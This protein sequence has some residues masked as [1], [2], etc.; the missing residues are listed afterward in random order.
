MQLAVNDV[1]FSGLITAAFNINKLHFVGVCIS[2]SYD[3]KY[4][5][6]VSIS[7]IK[8]VDFPVDTELN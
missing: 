5:A 6:I 4:T 1:N 2:V 8:F 7:S 3:P